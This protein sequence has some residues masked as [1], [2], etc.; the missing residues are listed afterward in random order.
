LVNTNSKRMF[1][2]SNCTKIDLKEKCVYI[3][4]NTYIGKEIK[5]RE[6]KWYKYYNTLI[7]MINEA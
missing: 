3:L 5:G 6:L 1:L 4:N 2:I 7:V